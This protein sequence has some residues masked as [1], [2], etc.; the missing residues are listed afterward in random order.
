MKA[1]RKSP[2][3]TLHAVARALNRAGWWVAAGLMLLM[4]LAVLLQ[5]G[6]RYLFFS[7]P[8][9]TEEL[10][11]YCMVWAGLLGATVTYYQRSDPVL[12]AAPAFHS[13]TMRITG[14]IVRAVA[15]LFVILPLLIYS[16]A[17]LE[18]HSLRSTVSLQWPSAFVMLIVPL[19]AGL[20]LL[21]LVLRTGCV[22]LGS[23]PGHPGC[24][25]RDFGD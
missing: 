9:W 22:L 24:H 11:R 18:H 14:E 8:S 19:F 20:I 7:P 17:V 25:D 1:W 13:R 23:V 16:P 5:V 10:A 6:A 3:D 4:L 15:V 2:A 21:H 12:V